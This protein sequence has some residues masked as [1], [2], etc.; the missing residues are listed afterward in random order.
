MENKPIVKIKDWSFFGNRLTGKVVNHPRFDEGTE[1][2]TSTIV[3]VETR[4]TVYELLTPTPK[5]LTS[6]KK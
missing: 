5:G 4:N 6:N 3:R 2:T 1:V